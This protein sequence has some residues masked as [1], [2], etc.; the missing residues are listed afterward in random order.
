MMIREG[1]VL[2]PKAGR[3]PFEHVLLSSQSQAAMRGWNS[4][5][6]N[7][8]DFSPKREAIVSRRPCISEDTILPK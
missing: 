7:A 6:L 8:P 4:Y 1:G 2:V 5:G 3:L